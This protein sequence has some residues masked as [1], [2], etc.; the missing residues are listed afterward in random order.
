MVAA[1]TDGRPAGGEMRGGFGRNRVDGR[2]GKDRSVARHTLCT[3]HTSQRRENGALGNG[4]ALRSNADRGGGRD[5]LLGGNWPRGRTSKTSKNE[6]AGYEFLSRDICLAPRCLGL[7]LEITKK[8]NLGVPKPS[9]QRVVLGVSAVAVCLR[10]RP[11]APCAGPRVA[12]CPT[13][14]FIADLASRGGVG[15][16]ATL[17]AGIWARPIGGYGVRACERARARRAPKTALGHTR[18]YG[19]HFCNN[20]CASAIARC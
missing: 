5:S 1:G 10:G 14:V 19:E 17:S 7:V 4:T 12:V 8:G 6:G 2:R 11:S 18:R 16:S 20:L 9:R 13:A 15:S 3:M